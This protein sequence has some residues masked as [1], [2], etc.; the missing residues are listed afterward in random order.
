MTEKEYKAKLEFYKTSDAPWE[1][2]E[3]FIARLKEQYEGDKEEKRRKILLDIQ[4]G[5]ADISDF[6]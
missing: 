4:E 5:A 6:N 1:V 3:S 2:K